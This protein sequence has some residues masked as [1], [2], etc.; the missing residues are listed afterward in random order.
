M[1]EINVPFQDADI[2]WVEL[3]E[4]YLTP[5][6]GVGIG[7]EFTDEKMRQATHYYANFTYWKERTSST[8]YHIACKSHTLSNQWRIQDLPCGGKHQP[9]MRTRT[10]YYA[11]FPQNT[12]E[13][14]KKL[15]RGASSL[16]PLLNP[17][18][19]THVFL[20]YF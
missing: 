2:P 16:C 6:F 13:N 10:Y 7:H 1:T 14:I 17:P 5:L 19:S 15:A 9:L 12:H 20:V 11:N 3:G 4:L 8:D 18:M